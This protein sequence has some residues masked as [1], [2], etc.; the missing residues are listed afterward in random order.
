MLIRSRGLKVGCLFA[1][2]SVLA[3]GLLTATSARAQDECLVVFD[4]A[5]TT[6]SITCNDCDPACDDDG[7]NQKNDACTFRLRVC[8]NASDATCTRA[9]LKKIKV[10]GKKA[11]AFKVT[12]NG[13]SSVCGAFVNYEVKLKKKGKK[14]GKVT[15][16]AKAISRD[17]PK[18]KD[19]DVLILTCNP[20]PA[21]SCPTTSTTTTTV[22]TSTTS[23]TIPCGNGVVGA[24][25]QCDP[26]GQ[27]AQCASGEVCDGTCQC[28][29]A[30]SCCPATRISTTSTAGI[31]QVSTLAPF[32]FPPG[33]ITIVEAGAGDVACKH[34]AIV[35][36]G[37]FSVPV[38][39][40]PALGFTSQVTPLGCE[41]GTAVGNGFVWDDSSPSATP[42][43]SRVGDTSDPSTASCGTLG[44]GCT[45]PVDPGEA[46]ADTAGN[47]DTTRGGAVS[48]V[49]GVHTQLDIPVLSTTWN[50]DDGNCPDDD[51]V[52]SPG[53][54][55]LVTQFNFI[56]SPTT[57]S[58]NADYTDLNGDACSFEGNGPDHVKHCDGDTSRPCFTN[59]HCSNP[60]P[61]SG[62]CVDGPLLGVP[63]AGPCCTV[64]Q[65]TT[66]VASGIAFTGGAPL[67]DL[68][69]ANKTPSSITACDPPSSSDT[70][71]LT[72]NACLD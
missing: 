56:L 10:M 41:T 2:A 34:N 8:G 64:G 60:P 14:A 58:S 54:D 37:G 55:T 19:T 72:T 23:T 33:V 42:D 40:I 16:K 31:L 61:A 46:G 35:P 5:P 68:V 51:G 24:G 43:V 44:G 50:D 67:Y 7:V 39:C 30:P 4:G 52:Y 48:T 65:T 29:A 70:C 27:Q 13:T 15:L 69:F 26:P 18:R 38:F 47:I 36:A 3:M 22:T 49:A 59:S 57:G 71:V 9:D 63:P 6:G 66:V 32:P 28:V 20:Q 17:K 62:N 25:E 45:L 11:K 21:A 12:A 1:F 53:T